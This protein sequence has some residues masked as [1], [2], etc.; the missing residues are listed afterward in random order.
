MENE[1]KRIR[2]EYSRRDSDEGLRSKYRLSNP[3]TLFIYQNIER[4]LISL[5]RR[6]SHLLPVGGRILDFG[7]GS[8]WALSFFVRLG[9]DPHQLSGC[10]LMPTR[11]KKA[12]HCLPKFVHLT[13]ANGG[14]L[15]Y[16]TDTFELIY[17]SM[18]FS[19]VLD[20]TLRERISSELWRVL[21]PGGAIISYDF[22]LCKRGNVRVRATKVGDLRDL[23]PDARLSYRRVTL[24]PLITYRLAPV[25]RLLA[26]VL[27][28]IPLLRSHTLAVLRKE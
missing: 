10:D 2:N 14:A 15:P 28:L 23:F 20:Q 25:S 5:F 3:G 17:T 4:E 1:L 9:I 27:N 22:H 7:C 12:V 16:R 21:K 13:T 19:S 11:V 8:G 6:E 18:V 24:L 26:E